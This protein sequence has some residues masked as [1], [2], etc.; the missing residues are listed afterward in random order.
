MS[1]SHEAATFEK[2]ADVQTESSTLIEGLPGHGLVAS[3]AVDQITTQLDLEYYGNVHSETFPPVTTFED[4]RVRDLVRVYAGEDPGV[5]TLQSDL[6]LPQE[7]FG[8]LAGAIVNGLSEQFDEAIF[9]AGVPAET[10][11]NHGEVVG[12]ATTEEVE[13]QLADAGI[14]LAEG[15]GLVGGVTGALVNDC[16]HA[17]V[18]AAVL[19]VRSNPYLPD[20]GAARAVIED[21]LEPLVDFDIDTTQLEEQA[22]EIQRKKAQI[23]QQ[24]K[25]Q[26]QGQQQQPQSPSMYQ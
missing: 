26:Q 6:P 20:P 12:V 10:K 22:E 18:P 5:M 8:P 23:A 3:I 1:D 14:T 25:Q 16:Y 13:G 7:S 21:A 15:N 2:L 24:L 9:L 4:G 11:E 17:D 19:V